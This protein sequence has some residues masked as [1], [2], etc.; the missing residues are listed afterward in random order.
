MKRTGWL[1]REWMT[2]KISVQDWAQKA[3]RTLNDSETPTLDVQV[4]MAFGLNQKREWLVANNEA[5]LPDDQLGLLENLL[6]R[7]Q[8]GE[9]LAY[10][11]GKRSFFGLDFKVSP[12]VLVPRPET[13]LLVEE[14]MHWLEINPSRRKAADVGC[15][16]GVIAIS[17]AD[18]FDD[19]RVNG[20]DISDAALQ[21]AAENVHLHGLEEQIKL[22]Q[23]DLLAG[24]DERFDLIAANLPYI[25]SATLET[26][27]VLQHEPRLALDGGPDGLRL[28]ERL[29]TQSL[30]S[31]L[32]RGLV[33]LEIEA[34]QGESALELAKRVYPSATIDCLHDYA[35][36]PRLI[37]ILT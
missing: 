13:E 26:L 15:G 30:Q 22:R 14:A 20:I 32:P 19:L 27:P 31:L 12:A 18:R 16:S 11:T 6:K 4:L 23:N 35:D 1:R 21:I 36:L 8:N 5:L 25:P 29:L 33:L 17:L 28:I 2:T 34:T 3:V 24:I 37:K 7:L 9:P 10:L